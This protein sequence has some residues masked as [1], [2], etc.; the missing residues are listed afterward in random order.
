MPTNATS[1]EMKD[2]QARIVESM[3]EFS[4]QEP[5]ITEALAVMNMTMPDYVRAMDA[6][7]GGQVV[8]VSAYSTVPLQVSF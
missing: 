4:A 3:E 1:E 5:A 6:I 8:S 7:R 2:L